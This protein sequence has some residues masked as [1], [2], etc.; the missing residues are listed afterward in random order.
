MFFKR[1]NKIREVQQALVEPSYIAR[2]TSFEGNIICD[3][4]I[5][6]DGAVRGSV[7]AQTCLVDANGEVHGE[8]T[9]QVI[10]V[11]GRVIGPVNGAHVHIHAGAH[12]E[13]NV[14][15]ETISIENG[16]YVYGSIRHGGAPMQAAMQPSM[17]P[18]MQPSMMVQKILQKEP[19]LNVDPEP[20]PA[21]EPEDNVRPIKS[22][23]PRP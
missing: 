12:V 17:P 14:T 10:Y 2:D 23:K 13:G 4:E 22:S 18:T 15:N 20:A 8:V 3:G 21:E 7:R 1:K 11:R 5:H 19:T 16:A 9:A 6:I